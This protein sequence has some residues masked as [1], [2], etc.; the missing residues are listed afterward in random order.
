VVDEGYGIISYK[1]IH[2]GSCNHYRNDTYGFELQL[3]D[4][5][6]GNCA[7]EECITVHPEEK[8]Q[9]AL[10]KFRFFYD[11]PDRNDWT[12]SKLLPNGWHDPFW[13]DIMSYDDYFSKIKN[14]TYEE[15]MQI[16]EKIAN[17][18]SYYF[19][20]EVGNRDWEEW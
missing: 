5:W 15:P 7:I 4:E 11:K 20:L 17:N 18:S 8:Q 13:I 14:F 10:L 2:Y 3:P 9:G 16:G 19:L 12:S 1:L 6:K